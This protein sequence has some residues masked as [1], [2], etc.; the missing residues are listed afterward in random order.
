[1]KE[2]ST[3]LGGYASA[4]NVRSPMTLSQV[5]DLLS[6]NLSSAANG[7]KSIIGAQCGALGMSHPYER[8]ESS[9]YCEVR[10]AD[11]L[12]FAADRIEKLIKRI[13]VLKDL[14]D[15]VHTRLT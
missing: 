3:I 6:G 14:A 7:L 5:N 9:V 15:K 13:Q 1:M 12:Q 2:E 4:V 8:P 10:S 11:P